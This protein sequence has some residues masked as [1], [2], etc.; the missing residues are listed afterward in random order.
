LQDT[1]ESIAARLQA[2][3]AY[4]WRSG[5]AEAAGLH[6]T[7]LPKQITR[8]EVDPMIPGHLEWSAATPVRHGPPRRA[9]LAAR[10]KARA[11]K[12]AKVA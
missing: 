2:V 10:A 11:R 8:G 5:H 4:G 1:S 12:K 9:K 3:F 7:N 6:F